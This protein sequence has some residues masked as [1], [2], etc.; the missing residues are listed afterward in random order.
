M[1]TFLF[2]VAGFCEGQLLVFCINRFVKKKRKVST[3]SGYG[4]ANKAS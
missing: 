1:V 3:S 4:V 2:F